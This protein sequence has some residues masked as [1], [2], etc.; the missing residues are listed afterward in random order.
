MKLV[1]LLLALVIEQIRPLPYARWVGQPLTRLSNWVESVFDS[2]NRQH[3][4]LAWLLIVGGGVLLAVLLD[5]ILS[6]LNLLLGL[7]FGVVVLY[8]TL[9]FR[10]F[11]H[12]FTE[13]NEALQADDV[14]AARRAM[15]AWNSECPD[16]AS[17]DE[18]ARL[19]IETGVLASHRHVFGVLAWFVVFGPVGAVFYRLTAFLAT[20]WNGSDRKDEELVGE[21]AAEEVQVKRRQFGAF[22]RK[23]FALVD[24][25][26][27]R[28][29]AVAFAI[30]GNFEDAIYCWREQAKSWRDQTAGV[31][32]A[33]GAGALG[34]KLGGE[35]SH[36][37]V[38]EDDAALLDRPEI[39]VGDEATPAI[40]PSAIGLVWR[41]LILWVILLAV[42][43]LAAWV[44]I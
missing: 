44:G 37:P 26:P 21:H 41:A 31:I 22:A 29:T 28:L 11:S 14:P 32:V 25:L 10:Q 24:W 35:L 27:A 39:G 42:V 38:I 3:G 36:S 30:V 34:V 4:F 17:S 20:H 23:A 40:L 18:I 9:G 5:A 7:A 13:V 1:V 8:L 33:A 6:G 16:N 43:G 12:A 19:A 15:K 2:G